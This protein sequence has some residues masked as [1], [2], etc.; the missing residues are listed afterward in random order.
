MHWAGHCPIGNRS[1]TAVENLGTPDQPTATGQRYQVRRSHTGGKL[2][3]WGQHRSMLA[4]PPSDS[5]AGPGPSR[6]RPYSGS[7]HARTHQGWR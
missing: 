4:E 3:V 7:V 1:E 2:V 6:A 5:G